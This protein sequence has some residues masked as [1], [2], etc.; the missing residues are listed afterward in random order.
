MC[1]SGHADFLRTLRSLRNELPDL[2]LLETTGLAHPGALAAVFSDATV[3]SCFELRA[4]II[5]VVDVSQVQA[6]LLDTRCQ[7]AINEAEAQ[8]LAAD[9]VLLNHRDRVS[10]SQAAAVSTQIQQLRQTHEL[11]PVQLVECQFCSELD[12]QDVLTNTQL[13]IQSGFDQMHLHDP[14]IVTIGKMHSG[15]VT[16]SRLQLFLKELH[17]PGKVCEQLYRTK[18][19]FYLDETE[20]LGL[21]LQGVV[22]RFEL[23]RALTEIE[24]HICR[25]VLIGRG[26]NMEELD[27]LWGDLTIV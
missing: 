10:F 3:A 11:C 27:R 23:S 2:V 26:F 1:C 7:G 8:L 18:G 24:G 21:L 12:I 22:E 9:L 4:P 19:I 17:E 20:K 6:Q 14:S 16:M 13:A 15:S 25:V 5:A